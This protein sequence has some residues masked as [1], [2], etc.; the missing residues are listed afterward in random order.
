MNLAPYRLITTK[1]RMQVMHHANN[2]GDMVLIHVISN[3]CRLN[4]AALFLSSYP[5]TYI[6]RQYFLNFSSDNRTVIYWILGDCL[7]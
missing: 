1:R 6:F 7:H 2:S 5:S 4:E 3:E